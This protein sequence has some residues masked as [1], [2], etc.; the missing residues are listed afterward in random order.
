MTALVANPHA[1]EVRANHTMPIRY[2]FRLPKRSPS[3]A[4]DQQQGGQGQRVA[5]HH[6]LQGGHAGVKVAPDGRQGDG[7][8][9]GVQHREPRAEHGDRQ[10][11]ASWP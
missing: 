9:G 7:D 11:P 10:H 1:A 5:V 6:P 4:A 8:D 2:T 3:R